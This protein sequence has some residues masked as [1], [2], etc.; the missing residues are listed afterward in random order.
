M[1]ETQRFA[2]RDVVAR[3]YQYADGDVLAFDLG[4]GAAGAVDVVDGT[5]M[6]VVDDE[7]FEMDLPEGR[8]AKATINNG[9]VTVEMNGSAAG[10]GETTDIDVRDGGSE[11][12]EDTEDER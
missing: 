5:L 4:A 6:V 3:Q 10:G 7:Q 9:V 8:P 12:D 2:E 11:A 1:A